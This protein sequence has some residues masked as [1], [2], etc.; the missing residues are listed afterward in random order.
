MANDT[1]LSQEL[2][3][4]LGS[5]QLLEELTKAL[6]QEEYDECMKYIARMHDIEIREG[7]DESP[8]EDYMEQMYNDYMREDERQT[9]HEL[10]N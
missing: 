7:W 5:E 3:D 2:Y 6:S 4:C 1:N 9:A 10:V 8:S